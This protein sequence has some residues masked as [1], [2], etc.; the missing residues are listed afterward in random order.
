VL[1]H[2][3]EPVPL[4]DWDDLRRL[5]DDGVEFG[6]HSVSHTYLTGLSHA[7]VIREAT[8]SQMALEREIGRPALAFSYPYG[9]TNEFVQHWIGGCGYIFG[10]TCRPG[11]AKSHD[12]LLGLPRIEVTPQ[13]TLESFAEKL[14]C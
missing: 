11:P 3:S 9:D 12:R 1:Q 7:E 13:D 5:R 2:G 8:Q 14:T 6:S 10:L 4:L